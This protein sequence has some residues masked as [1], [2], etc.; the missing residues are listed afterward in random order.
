MKYVLHGPK[1]TTEFKTAQE[2]A[3]YVATLKEYRPLFTVGEYEYDSPIGDYMS[4]P[5]TIL[6][7]DAWLYEYIIQRVVNSGQKA[8]NAKDD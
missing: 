3:K 5:T 7:A 6:R 1:T 4:E 8:N 2:C